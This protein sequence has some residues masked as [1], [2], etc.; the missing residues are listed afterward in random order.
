[1]I[2]WAKSKD[3]NARRLQKYQF[4]KIKEQGTPS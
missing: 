1:M 4:N 2:R 3:R